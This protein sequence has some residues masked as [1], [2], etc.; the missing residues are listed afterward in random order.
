MSIQAAIGKAVAGENLSETEMESA[1]RAIML[2]QATPAQIAGLLVALRMK[3]ETVDEIAAAARVMRE[4]AAKVEIGGEYLVDIVG[5]GGDASN[6]FNI[7]TTAAFVIT[8]A[9]GRVAKHNNRSVS[10]RSGSADVLE[11]AGVRVNLTPSQVAQCVDQIGVGFMFAP[12]H[13]GATK[14]AAGPRRELG[15]RTLFNLLGPLTN[16][17]GVRNLV[18]GVY[19]RERIVTMARV[20]QKLGGRHV[21]VVHS[22]DGLDEISVAAPTHV[23]E[24]AAGTVREFQVTPEELGV[25]RGD[26]SLLRVRDAR[27]SLR[28]MHSA[29]DNEPGPA[30]DIVLL[31]AGAALHVAGLAADLKSGVVR[32]RGAIES[33]KARR[34]LDELVRLTTGLPSQDLGPGA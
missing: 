1:M 6:T 15:I 20:M 29:L 12:A 5:T 16:P 32:A 4:F 2:G 22:E 27:D 11:A 10:S 33:G 21:L 7:S 23:A 28:L 17:A 3:G 30:R 24:L 31:N 19:A 13:H 34:K 26:L 14:H 18:I 25:P 8:A 9:G